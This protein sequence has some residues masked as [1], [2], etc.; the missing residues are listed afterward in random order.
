MQMDDFISYR[1]G[2][3]ENISINSKGVLQDSW[4]YFSKFIY[5]FHRLIL[6]S[7]Y[8]SFPV[9][10]LVFIIQQLARY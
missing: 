3:M 7:F 10:L 5:L 9:A 2:A 4:F 1:R 8:I 6:P